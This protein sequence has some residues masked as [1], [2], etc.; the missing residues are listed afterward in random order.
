MRCELFYYP[1]FVLFFHRTFVLRDPLAIATKFCMMIGSCCIFDLSTSDFP[2]AT[3]KILKDKEWP[4]FPHPLKILRDKNDQ[5]LTF[6]R[7]QLTLCAHSFVR[8]QFFANKQ[9]SVNVRSFDDT[10]LKNFHNKIFAAGCL[11]EIGSLGVTWHHYA[12]WFCSFR[13]WRYINHLLTYLLTLLTSTC[14]SYNAKWCHLANVRTA[15]LWALQWQSDQHHH[16][17]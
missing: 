16:T 14:S 10:N 7:P 9:H 13:L 15:F 3:P 1:T 12:P 17:I 11:V 6:F 4:K 2:Y 8:R 5:N